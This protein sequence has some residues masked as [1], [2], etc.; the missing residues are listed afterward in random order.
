[1]NNLDENEAGKGEERIEIGECV[2]TELE[3]KANGGEMSV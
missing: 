1:M 3:G 2:G